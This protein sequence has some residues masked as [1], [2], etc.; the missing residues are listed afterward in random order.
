MFLMKAIQ[1]RYLN[2]EEDSV[3]FVMFNVKA[4]IF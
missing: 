3:A 2:S 1:D 4:E